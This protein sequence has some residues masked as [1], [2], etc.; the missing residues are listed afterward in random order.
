MKKFNALL[1]VIP[2]DPEEEMEC[3]E[4]ENQLIKHFKALTPQQRDRMMRN[5]LCFNCGNPG[6]L[7]R[8]CPDKTDPVKQFEAVLALASAADRA[9]LT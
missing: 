7:A 9:A 3:E 1:D 5:K 2:P 6:H 8:D 4:E